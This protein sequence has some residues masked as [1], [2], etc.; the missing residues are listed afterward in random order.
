MQTQLWNDPN[1]FYHGVTVKQGR[2]I[3]VLSGP[4]VVF[5]ADERPARPN[6]AASIEGEQLSLF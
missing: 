3:F 4:L 5:V 2:E 6:K 1:G